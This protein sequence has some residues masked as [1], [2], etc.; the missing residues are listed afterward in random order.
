MKNKSLKKQIVALKKRTTW[1][2][3]GHDFF[4]SFK[5][6]ETIWLLVLLAAITFFFLRF[7]THQ[8]DGQSMEPTFQTKDRILISQNSEPSRYAVV[9]F[10]PKGKKNES[11]VKRI[12][13]MPGDRIQLMGNALFLLPK[14]NESKDKVDLT[15]DVP[16]GTIKVIVSAAVMKQ[17]LQYERIPENQYFVQGDNRLHSDDSRVFGLIDEAQIEGIVIYRYYPFSK[18]GTVH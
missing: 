3:I 9:T 14:E 2:K 13:G 15:K 1:K 4:Q 16:D 5:Q 18:I 6:K 10:E 17:L 12:I 8:V 7:S 11:Y